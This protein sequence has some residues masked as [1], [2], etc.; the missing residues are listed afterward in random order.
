MMKSRFM[1]GIMIASLLFGVTWAVP[2]T[3]FAGESSG[4]KNAA[5]EKNL[6]VT[7]TDCTNEKKNDSLCTITANVDLMNWSLDTISLEE[8]LTASLFYLDFY[9]YPAE[10]T[11]NGGEKEIGMLETAKGQLS[12]TVPNLAAVNMADLTLKITANGKTQE[13]EVD[14][15]ASLDQSIDSI[16]VGEEEEGITDIPKL[17]LG[18]AYIRDSWDGKKDEK[19]KWL[20]QEIELVN[21]SA[22]PIV[23]DE[24][25]SAQLTYLDDYTFEPEINIPEEEVLP[26]QRI[27][28]RLIFNVPTI[29]SEAAE[30][31]ITCQIG[32]SDQSWVEDVV[33]RATGLGDN[34]FAE[35]NVG[36]LVAFGRYEQDGDTANGAE[37]IEWRVLAIEDGKALVISE[38]ALDAKPYNVERVSIT[39]EDCTLRKWLNEDFCQEAFTEDEQALIALTQVINED[40]PDCET[41]GG[42]DTE[43]NVFLL[44]IAETNDY[45]ADNESGIAFATQYAKDNGAWVSDSNGESVWWLRSPGHSSLH[46]ACVGS[47]GHVI[48]DGHLVNSTFGVVRPALFID[49]ES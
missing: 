33:I 32:L 18:K 41:E 19:H 28:G 7:V 36:D 38:Y 13:Q 42:S 47:L 22:I 30:G 3:S 11:F 4:Q 8:D 9:E 43:D 5:K 16:T 46:A 20:I 15:S 6:E 23:I 12:V 40:N 35:A 31:E 26:L 24:S 10:F 2:I 27:R 1:A 37:A 45:F 14:Y 29:V 21:W 49:L 25:L 17:S 34:P 44:S 39:W 48:T